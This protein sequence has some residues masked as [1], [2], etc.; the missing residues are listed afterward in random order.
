MWLDIFICESILFY[1]ILCLKFL[2]IINT[3]AKKKIEI[4]NSKYNNNNK[5][6]HSDS[7]VV[8]TLKEKNISSHIRNCLGE[9][10]HSDRTCGSTIHVSPTQKVMSLRSSNKGKDSSN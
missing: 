4:R 6:L 5:Q 7:L 9:A 8:Q 3:R 10:N 1:Y 2:K